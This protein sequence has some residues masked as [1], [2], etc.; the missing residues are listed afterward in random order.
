MPKPANIELAQGLAQQN[1][2]YTAASTNIQ[3]AQQERQTVMTI[4]SQK[5]AVGGAGLAESGSALDLLASSASQG[6]LAKGVLVTQGQMQQA[7]YEEQA[8]SYGVMSA[9]AKATAAGE[10]K[11]SGETESIAAQQ[12]QLATE[13]QQAGQQAATGDFVS[14]ALKGVA[15]VAS[16]AAAPATGGLSLAPSRLAGMPA[17]CSQ[18]LIFSRRICSLSEQRVIAEIT[19]L[20]G[21]AGLVEGF[22]KACDARNTTYEATSE[23]AGLP[24]RYVNKILAPVP[25]RNIGPK[26]LGPALGRAGRQNPDYRGFG[27]AGRAGKAICA[28]RI[29][30]RSGMRQAGMPSQETP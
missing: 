22:R 20:D 27:H 15:A 17:C 3:A 2:A 4:G 16:I 29:P 10:V 19:S 23:L 1:A 14:A 7:G 28:A 24:T 12:R 25:V 30:A 18:E 5:A 6:A 8:N 21:W 9:A 11:I 26:S 13:T